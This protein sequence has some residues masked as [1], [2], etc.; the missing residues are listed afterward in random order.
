M[1]RAIRSLFFATAVLAV[2]STGCRKPKKG[3]PTPVGI[4]TL[5]SADTGP[6]ASPRVHAII[7]RLSSPDEITRENASKE[8]LTLKRADLELDD[9]LAL[10]HAASKTYP[11]SAQ[12]SAAVA[13]LRAAANDARTEHIEG[14][15]AIYPKLDADARTEALA[16]L[17]RIDDRE[18]IEALV[19]LVKDDVAKNRTTD[20]RLD[21]L[22]VAKHHASV[23]FPELLNHAKGRAAGGIY[24]TAIVLLESYGIEPDV[25][26]P[27]GS[28][29]V[30]TWNELKTKATKERYEERRHATYALDLMAWLPK[31]EVDA[32]LKEALASDDSLFNYW[33]AVGLLDHGHRVSAKQLDAIASHPELR[34]YLYDRLKSDKLLHLFPA[35]HKN[36]RSL[37]EAD[38]ARFLSGPTQL[39]RMPGALEMIDV[40]AEKSGKDVYELYVFRFRVDAPSPLV[41]A[42]RSYEWMAGVAGPY[43]RGTLTTIQGDETSSEYHPFH[44]KTVE[45]HKA[46]AKATLHFWIT[47]DDEAD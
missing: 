13:L 11:K 20:V 38:M 2:L 43:K 14:I 37:A 29:V 25:F 21:S 24:A 23:L 17:S 19:R 47:G 16:L 10:V 3:T 8:L 28:T 39:G 18:A 46:D 12:G 36:Q 7:A 9:S 27:Y 5:T 41:Q 42:G 15:P 22:D 35:K 45:E 40:V 34:G 30:G 6:K 4:A 1:Q 26:A 31:G 44:E 33:G 32:S